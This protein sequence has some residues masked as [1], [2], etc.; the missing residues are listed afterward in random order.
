MPSLDDV[1]NELASIADEFTSADF[2]RQRELAQRRRELHALAEVWDTA[3]RRE[4]MTEELGRLKVRVENLEADLIVTSGKRKKGIRGMLWGEWNW[5]DD[6]VALNE[7]IKVDH[8]AAS[9]AE[10]IA[11]LERK[12]GLNH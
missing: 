5:H 2:A 1:F 12:L 9:L 8:D 3:A 10:K 4:A 6:A 7:H 11:N